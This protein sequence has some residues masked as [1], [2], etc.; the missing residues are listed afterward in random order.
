MV[1]SHGRGRNGSGSSSQLVKQEH[2]LGK[3]RCRRRDGLPSLSKLVKKPMI[4][5][6][7]TLIILALSPDGWERL[8]RVITFLSFLLK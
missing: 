6:A 4:V 8:E 5:A 1:R 2:N 7:M 3:R